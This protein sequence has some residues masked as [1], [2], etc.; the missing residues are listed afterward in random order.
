MTFDERCHEAAAL[1]ERGEHS[2]A[3][4]I[5]EEL[6]SDETND[7]FARAMMCYNIAR[8]EHAKGS[9]LGAMKA[10]ERA[11][12]LALYAYVF[13]QLHRVSW[14]REVGRDDDARQLLER[15]MAVPELARDDRAMCE[16]HLRA[17]RAAQS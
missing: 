15:L 8:C 10:F 4:R 17:I 3:L 11:A 9:R 14:L 13:V 12:G 16:E 7:K 1:F 6:A 5:F 2:A